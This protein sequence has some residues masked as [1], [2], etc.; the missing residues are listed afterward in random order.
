MDYLW[1]M[2][3]KVEHIKTETFGISFFVSD[4]DKGYS[5]VSELANSVIGVT[6]DGTGHVQNFR[7]VFKEIS[8]YMRVI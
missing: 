5:Q 7:D 1:P 6:K 3:V 2:N 8:N 4:P